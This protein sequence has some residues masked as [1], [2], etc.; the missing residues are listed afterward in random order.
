MKRIFPYPLALIAAIIL[1]RVAISSSQ[2]GVDQ[3]LRVLFTLLFAAAAAMLITQY[4][5]KDWRYTNFIVVLIPVALVAYRSLYRLL[6][7]SFP[8]LANPLGIVL[9]ILLAVLYGAAV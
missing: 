2:M 4:F 5:V 6:K 1:D 9:L 8:H 3:S 7:T